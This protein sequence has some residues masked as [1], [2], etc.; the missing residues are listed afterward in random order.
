MRRAYECSGTLDS[1]LEENW[2]LRMSVRKFA[3]IVAVSLVPIAGYATIVDL[4]GSNDSGSI[5]G[6]QFVFTTHQPTGTGVIEAFLRIE[7][8]PTEFGAGDI[9]HRFSFFIELNG[10]VLQTIPRRE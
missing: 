5:N 4:T 1:G 7:N 10:A 8:T 6:A 9:D 2:A 3:F